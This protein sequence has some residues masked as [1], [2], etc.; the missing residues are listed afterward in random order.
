MPK[1]EVE[2]D[3]LIGFIG[4]TMSESELEVILE[5]AKGEIDESTD[6]DGVMKV[7]L[8]DTNRPDL[9]STAGLGRQLRLYLGGEQPD[10]SFFSTPTATQ[11]AGE[12][13]V[14]VDPALHEVRPYIAAF[15]VSGHAI[16]DGELRDLIQTQEKLTTNFGRHRKAIAMGVYRTRLMTYPVQ[17]RAVDPLQTSFVP[18]G[19][20]REMNLREIIREHPKGQDYGSIVESFERFPFLQDDNGE[21]LSFPPI[22][23][24]ARIGAVEEGD[25]ELFIELTGTDLESVLLACSIAACDMA[26]AGHTVLPVAIEYPYDTQFGRTIV[27]PYAFQ[28]PVS[29][30]TEYITGLIGEALSGDQT[31]ASLATMGVRATREGNSI[32]VAPPEYRNDFL[33]PVDVVE[34]VAIGHGMRNFTPEMPRDFTVG[35]LTEAEHFNRAAIDIMVGLGFQEMVF[36]NMGSGRDFITKMRP[37]PLSE[38]APAAADLPAPMQPI[39]LANPMSENYEYVRSSII[40]QLLG[41]ESVSANAAYPHHIFEVGKVAVFDDDDV[42][43]TRTV[44]SLGFVSADASA[45]FTAAGAHVRA[46]LYYLGVEYTL[47]AGTDERFIPGR[48]AIIAATDGEGSSRDVGVLGE[49]HPQ[50]LENNGIQVP[51]TAVEIDLDAVRAA[52]G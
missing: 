26:D 49:L 14:V 47:R 52:R 10:Y 50:V 44:N 13:R 23:N 51:T 24:S 15:A 34:D 48:C 46:L 7:E 4:K 21:V 42:Q 2:Y 31:V 20:T 16:D 32:T 35:R 27:T 18:L 12:R 6:A 43:G 22:I 36:P 33:H 28:E 11:D 45:G 17:Y 30:T 40:P 41:A 37:H 8:N 19:E 3:R 5:A 25:D 29:T 39:R 1:I 9:W 38:D